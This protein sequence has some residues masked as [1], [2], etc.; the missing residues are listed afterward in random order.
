MSKVAYI[1]ILVGLKCPVQIDC[2]NSRPISATVSFPESKSVA[3]GGHFPR[4]VRHSCVKIISNSEKQ[5]NERFHATTLMFK[6]PFG[7]S[8]L[9]QE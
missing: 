7:G 9:R 8:F 3:N 1:D 6:Y 5:A 2:N 4:S